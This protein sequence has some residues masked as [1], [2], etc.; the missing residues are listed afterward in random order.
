MED[1]P[2]YFSPGSRSQ[3]PFSLS[4]FTS[5]RQDIIIIIGAMF[6]PSLDHLPRQMLSAQPSGDYSEDN[7]KDKNFVCLWNGGLASTSA[8]AAERDSSAPYPTI[9]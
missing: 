2:A 4:L 1:R 3:P 7:I 8:K 9:W 5:F 6:Y